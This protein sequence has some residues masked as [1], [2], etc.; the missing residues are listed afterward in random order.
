ML[1]V[2]TLPLCKGNDNNQDNTVAKVIRSVENTGL[3]GNWFGGRY[4][5]T[6]KPAHKFWPGDEECPMRIAIH[7][8]DSST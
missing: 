7:A 8:N 2:H 1:T 6:K 3:Y 5:L 4:L